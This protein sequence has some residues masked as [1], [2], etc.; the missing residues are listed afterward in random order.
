[1]PRGSSRGGTGISPAAATRGKNN[2]CSASTGATVSQPFSQIRLRIIGKRKLTDDDSAKTFCL[3]A[4]Q[5]FFRNYLRISTE[6][7]GSGG[8]RVPSSSLRLGHAVRTSSQSCTPCIGRLYAYQVHRFAEGWSGSHQP[9]ALLNVGVPSS[10]QRWMSASRLIVNSSPGRPSRTKPGQPDS[11]HQGDRESA[12]GDRAPLSVKSGH[13]V[14][15]GDVSRCGGGIRSCRRQADR[16]RTASG[17]G[18]VHLLPIAGLGAAGRAG[19]QLRNLP[20]CR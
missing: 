13:F 2:P 18:G 4:P 19:A 17:G 11:E 16:T 10:S 15:S 20:G 9:R 3:W 7:I 14:I 1:M 5:E 6:F 8:L 12:K